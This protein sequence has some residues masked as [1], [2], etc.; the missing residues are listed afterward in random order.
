MSKGNINESYGRSISS[1]FFMNFMISILAATVNTGFSFSNSLTLS[2]VT[3]LLD[4]THTNRCE[5]KSGSSFNL[6]YCDFWKCQSLFKSFLYPCFFFPKNSLLRSIVQFSVRSF[7]FLTLCFLISLYILNI[8]P[9][10]N[11]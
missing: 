2:V 1:F 4:C 8:N 3:W 10:S 9:P 7:A 11:V 6:H 5:M